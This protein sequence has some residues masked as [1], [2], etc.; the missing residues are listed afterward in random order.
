VFQTNKRRKASRREKTSSSSCM[1][2]YV[3]NIGL[4]T[5]TCMHVSM[6]L[7]V[8]TYLDAIR[9]VL[10]YGRPARRPVYPRRF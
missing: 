6:E 2:L 7:P 5:S 9:D 10:I 3:V 8:Y 4:A 1:D